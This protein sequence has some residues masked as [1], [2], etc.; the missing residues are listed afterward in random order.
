MTTTDQSAPGVYDVLEQLAS[1]EPDPA[2]SAMCERVGEL[3]EQ[4]GPMLT[5]ARRMLEDHERAA[6][7]QIDALALAQGTE[8]DA[9]DGLFELVTYL[10]GA[11][12][13][14]MLMWQLRDLA[15]PDAR[16]ATGGP[17]VTA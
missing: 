17:P 13:L 10:S 12:G 1:V 15:D 16:L 2:I 11:Y 14:H 3:I 7:E 9:R 8:N 5:E 6:G 4:A